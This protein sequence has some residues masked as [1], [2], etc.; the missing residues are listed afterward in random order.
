[1]VIHLPLRSLKSQVQKKS[2]KENRELDFSKYSIRHI[3][4][5]IAYLG[6]SYKGFASQADTDETVEGQLFHALEKT[7][8]IINRDEA[9]YSRCGRTDKGVSALSQVVSLHVR[10]NVLEGEGIVSTPST[11]SDKK[12]NKPAQEIN[13]VKAINSALPEDIRVLAW[14]PVPTHFDA[15]F[16]TLYRTYKYFFAKENLNIEV[17]ITCVKI[18]D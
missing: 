2:K 17:F 9:N 6:W 8:L 1:M 13:Y 14:A 18:N 15:R 11:P 16:S 7:K 4:L 3:A 5:K 12:Q 10:S